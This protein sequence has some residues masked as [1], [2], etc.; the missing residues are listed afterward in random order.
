MAGIYARWLSVWFF[1]IFIG[2]PAV[3][4]AQVYMLQAHLLVYETTL[5]SRILIIW[6]AAAYLDA[7]ASIILYSLA[8][9]FFNSLLIVLIFRFVKKN[10]IHVNKKDIEEVII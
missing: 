1:S 7:A 2:T 4:L 10:H 3:M 9:A 8:G 6:G 5:L